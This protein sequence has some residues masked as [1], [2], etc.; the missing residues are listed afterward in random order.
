MP[1]VGQTS[2]AY[3]IIV[4]DIIVHFLKVHFRETTHDFDISFIECANIHDYSRICSTV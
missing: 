1:Q 3:D 4:H 2:E